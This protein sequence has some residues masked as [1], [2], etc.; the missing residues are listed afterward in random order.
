MILQNYLNLFGVIW[1]WYNKRFQAAG[2]Q[3]KVRQSIRGLGQE[4]IIEVKGHPEIS[5]IPIYERGG[6]HDG[7]N[8]KVLTTIQG[9]IKVVDAK[10]N[11]SS[12]GKIDN[13]W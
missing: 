2:Y 13:C 3:V 9:S 12:V 10:T 1:W 8:Y 5:Q 7:S 11:N 6:R 4:V